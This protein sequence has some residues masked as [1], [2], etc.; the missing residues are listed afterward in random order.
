MSTAEKRSLSSEEYLAIERQ[1]E[2]K[3]EFYRGEMFAMTGAS[4]KHNLLGSQM[5]RL[6]LNQLDN[7]P[8]E[9]YLADMRVKVDATGL[10]TYPDITVV[11]GEPQFEDDEVDTLLNP[12]TIFEILSKSTEAYD[13]GKKFAHY[14]N[15]PSL[16][17]FVLVSQQEIHLERFTR[18]ADGTWN[19]WESSNSEDTL[20][21]D[22]IGCQLKLGDIY[23]KV[24]FD[25]SDS[26]D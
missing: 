4:R 26:S 19:L 22:A 6:I 11:C 1:A 7:R 3:S 9:A 24:S 5:C 18:Q 8:C 15:L 23:A 17:Q 20:E 16:Q 13:R 2:T 10:Y 21:L 25:A 14:R 12:T